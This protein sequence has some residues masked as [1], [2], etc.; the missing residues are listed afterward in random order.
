M[1]IQKMT[2]K[3][4]KKCLELLNELY[5]KPKSLDWNKGFIFGDSLKTLFILTRGIKDFAE[6]EV[7]RVRSIGE[8]EDLTDP[9]TYKYPPL[10]YNSLGRMNLVEKQI[11]YSST[12]ATT[13]ILE[14]LNTGNAQEIVYLAVWKF[15]NN[16]KKSIDT[17][18]IREFSDDLNYLKWKLKASSN[19]HTLKLI[20]GIFD[21]YVKL[22]KSKNYNFSA[23]F[24]HFLVYT[25]NICNMIKYPSVVTDSQSFNYAINIDF[26][27][28][29]FEL[30]K[31]Y[32]IDVTGKVNMGELEGKNDLHVF[33]N[34]L[35]IGKNE[36][37]KIIF[38][39]FDEGKDT[40]WNKRGRKLEIP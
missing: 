12:C 25:H 34:P 38:E 20:K 28:E 29:E 36:N 2:N 16:R 22:Y 15:K 6:S 5:K 40:F 17:F 30:D 4:L 18:Q 14:Y 13:A 19:S 23:P 1:Y 39:P 33:M 3:D 24:S 10:E 8:K 27:D 9:K 35:E 7:Y 26:F 11:L 21:L 31:V 37:N 32:K